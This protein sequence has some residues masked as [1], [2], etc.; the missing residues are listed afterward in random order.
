MIVC[1]VVEDYQYQCH[2]SERA[3]DDFGD[4]GDGSTKGQRLIYVY[5]ADDDDNASVNDTSYFLVPCWEFDQV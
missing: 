5:K 3:S 1:G 2:Y 4:D